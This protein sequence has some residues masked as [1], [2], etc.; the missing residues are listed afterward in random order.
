[1]DIE[2]I[3]QLTLTDSQLFYLYD[4]LDNSVDEDMESID[5]PSEALGQGTTR[6]T[7]MAFAEETMELFEVVKKKVDELL[8]QE[9][10]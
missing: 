9:N 6:E 10:D 7:R 3:H 2:P 4:I 1:M 5:N 8:K